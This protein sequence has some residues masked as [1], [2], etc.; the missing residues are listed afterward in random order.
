MFFKNEIISTDFK[1][2]GNESYNKKYFQEAIINYNKG[3][4]NADSDIQLSLLYANRSA[5]YFEVKRFKECIENIE[6][7][8]LY[9][10]PKEKLSKLILRENNCKKLMQQ[11]ITFEDEE[12]SK[13]FFQL[14]YKSNEKV[15]F[16]IDGV[17]LK[18]SDQFGRYLT[19]KRYLKAGDIIA[20]E[21]PF[22]KWID[23]ESEMRFQR[24]ATCLGHN[25][26]NLIPCEKCSQG[27]LL[28]FSKLEILSK[29]YL[30]AYFITVMYCS[31]ECVNKKNFHIMSCGKTPKEFGMRL[32][33]AM[34]VIDEY[35]RINCAIKSDS[36]SFNIQSTHSKNKTI[37]D[38]KENDRN[39][40]LTILASLCSFG[41]ESN[42]HIPFIGDIFPILSQKQ[43]EEMF[44]S[45]VYV[46]EV[47][48]ANVLAFQTFHDGDEASIGCAL[49]LFGSLFN[50]SCAPNVSRISYNDKIVFMTTRPVKIGEQLFISYGPSFHHSNLNERQEELQNYKFICK[51][52]ACVNNW[53]DW[54][55][56][57]KKTR[58]FH[59]PQG[60]EFHSSVKSMIKQFKKN[61]DYINKNWNLH[62]CYETITLIEN[63]FNLT[64]EIGRQRL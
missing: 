58:D 59:I 40:F 18:Y 12:A 48:N 27:L 2:L 1:N 60:P 6:L 51:C 55:N 44:E 33:A 41:N 49:C 64:A 54:K 22:L 37:F 39:N 50:H 38:F 45:L 35:F 13:N 52:Q 19:T 61:C 30:F 11:N 47:I 29:I 7:A 16:I 26:L 56:V 53:S 15:P 57:M 34:Q 46:L 5:A 28:E 17:Q 9:G 36:N 8:K 32:E 43:Q 20:I 10:Y 25:N 3:L 62:P 31:N 42:F 21:D 24:C 14:T 4:C 63:N 23:R